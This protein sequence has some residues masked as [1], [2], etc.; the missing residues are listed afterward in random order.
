MRSAMIEKNVRDVVRNAS[1]I[2]GRENIGSLK[3]LRRRLSA[4]GH[5]DADISAAMKYIGSTPTEGLSMK[6]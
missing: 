6:P 3:H 2:V 1:M 5:D 4:E